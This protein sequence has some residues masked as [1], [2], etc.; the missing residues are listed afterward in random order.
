MCCSD[1]YARRVSTPSRTLNRDILR[2]A[3]PALGALIAEPLF[4]LTDS[5]LVGHLGA[6]PLAGLALGGA[7]LQTIVGLMVFLAYSTTPRV[8]RALGE[9]DE[10]RAVAAGIDGGWLALALGAVIAVAGAIAAPALIGR[11]EAAGPLARLAAGNAMTP[12]LPVF[13]AL[14]LGAT[15]ASLAAGAGR[16]MHLEFDHG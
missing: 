5:A 7:V 6:V 2:L 13:E 14:A 4:L 1:S 11:A 3:V 9:G 15:H 16:T 12:M 8:G 10:R